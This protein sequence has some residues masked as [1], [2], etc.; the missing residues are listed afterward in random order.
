MFKLSLSNSYDCISFS[1]LKMNSV[2]PTVY[3][4]AKQVPDNKREAFLAEE[5]EGI[6]KREGLPS[7]PSEKGNCNIFPYYL[8]FLITPSPNLV[9]P[10]I[11]G[12]N[13]DLALVLLAIPRCSCQGQ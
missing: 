10:V 12:S 13:A 7:N 3:K 6:L 4:K 2:A 8:L 9:L 1:Q 5:L 11:L